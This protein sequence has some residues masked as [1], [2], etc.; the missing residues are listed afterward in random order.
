MA[1]K[2]IIKK[3]AA[4]KKRVIKKAAAKKAPLSHPR[5]LAKGDQANEF[6]EVYDGGDEQYYVR[7]FGY[8]ITGDDKKIELSVVA[9][10][11]DL[12]GAVSEDELPEEGN[13]Q[14]SFSLVPYGNFI[15]EKFKESAN[16]E[17]ASI[18]SNT[19][20]NIV[21]YMGGLR[22]EPSEKVFF[23]TKDAAEKHLK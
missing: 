4:P 12:E 13:F 20:V 7:H 10:I 5:K 8:V 23:K 19:L 6:V 15:A 18:S 14:L 16:D 1:T 2:R 21:N 9:H 3:A 17:D 22:Y 11:Q